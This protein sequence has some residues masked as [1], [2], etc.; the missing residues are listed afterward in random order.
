MFLRHQLPLLPVCTALIRA[1]ST[2]MYIYG[3]CSMAT[4]VATHFHGFPIGKMLV[5]I[6]I[7]K[8]V[9]ILKSR[10]YAGHD[11]SIEK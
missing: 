5:S 7:L 3:I 1:R 11:S 2:C 10:N 6:N 9:K 8:G 4:D